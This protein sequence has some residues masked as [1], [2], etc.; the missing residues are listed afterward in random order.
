MRSSFI[1]ALSALAAVS[2]A[3]ADMVSSGWYHE[4]FHS[5]QGA[6]LPADDVPNSF[7]VFPNST[8]TIPGLT[9]PNS[10][11]SNLTGTASM[12][13]QS[14]SM[15]VFV[16]EP[17]GSASASSLY[18]FEVDQ[19][20]SFAISGGM[21]GSG[22]NALF[23]WALYRVDS[24]NNVLE[25]LGAEDF[26]NGASA[27]S[28]AAFAFSVTA[29]SGTFFPG[30]RYLFRSDGELDAYEGSA[31]GNLELLVTTVPAPASALMG[32]IGLAMLGLRRSIV[33][34]G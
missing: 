1:G 28:A 5:A 19:P 18:W 25:T 9:P 16:G 26:D 31:D 29:T 27:N 12:A 32:L 2:C 13:A 6:A 30:N 3:G 4:V 7:G 11:S 14:F 10:M 8:L 34:A 23:S 24:G 21:S 20:M 33:R 15:N 17:G 22:G